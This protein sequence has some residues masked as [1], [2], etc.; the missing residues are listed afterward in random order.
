MLSRCRTTATVLAILATI[1]RRCRVERVDAH[2]HDGNV[3]EATAL[4]G[5][6]DQAIRCCFKGLGC[7]DLA[8]L[9]VIDQGVQAMAAQNHKVTGVRQRFRFII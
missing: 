1:Q 3:I 7:D 2:N 5:Q 9:G 6:V 4:I 8:D